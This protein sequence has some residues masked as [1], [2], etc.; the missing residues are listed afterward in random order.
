LG[1]VLGFIV[2]SGKLGVASASAQVPVPPVPVL[3]V[4]VPSNPANHAGNAPA[5]PLL[6]VPPRSW[7]VD[8]T[9]N[10]LIVLHHP[11]SYLHYRMHVV[12]EKGDKLRDVIESKDG[13]VARL[14]MRD[15]KPLTK[16]QD[17]GERNRLNDIIASPS[18]FAQHIKNENSGKK[19]ADD[20][21]RLMPDAM[22]YTYVP[23][24]PQ[25][26]KTHGRPEI[27]M[28]Y[29]PNPK[30][31]PPTTTSAALTGLRGRVWID[32]STRNVVG[33]EGEVF[34]GVNLGWGLLAH[35]YPG[36]KLLLEQTSV[37][38]Q[39]WIFTHF[40]ERITVRALM[41]KTLN[42]RSNI[43]GEDFHLIPPIPYQD[44]IRMLLDTPLPTY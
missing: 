4:Q 41:V 40:E 33:I 43:D 9:A 39:R 38:E 12:D 7:A 22:I 44:A 25:S 16:E 20:L 42:V 1:L 24:Q 14:I 5:N 13:T 3:P 17:E 15:G 23:D 30:W 32:A 27:V 31:R 8:A 34:Q 18:G 10:E 6:A 11:N 29:A 26:G 2:I 37:G 35:I 21:I 28:D 19:I 36:G